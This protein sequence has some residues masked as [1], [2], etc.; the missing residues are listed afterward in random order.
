DVVKQRVDREIAT[1]GILFGCSKRV[2][3][4]KKVR[5]FTVGRQ[6]LMVGMMLR[7]RYA[8]LHDLLARLQL[9]TKRGDLDHLRT[10]PDVRQPESPADD[11]T[12]SKEFLDLV[13]MGRGADIEVFRPSAQEEVA[14]APAHQIGDVIALSQPV[15]NFQ[16]IGVDIAPRD[17]VLLARN[18]PRF[19]HCGH[20]TKRSG[21]H[22]RPRPADFGAIRAD[23][24]RLGVTEI[25]LRLS[26]T[27]AG[28]YRVVSALAV[29]AMWAAVVSAAETKD[30]LDRARALYNQRQFEAAVAAAD[31]VRKL[32]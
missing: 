24:P 5:R 16:C 18:Y 22:F 14:D 10:E 2:V 20:C 11:P 7:G 19:D 27:I 21:A 13:G 8:V 25:R 4:V 31:E 28:M 17:R 23:S 32:P 3:V 12:V 29:L 1:E 15:E 26:V 6:R 30:P 9:S